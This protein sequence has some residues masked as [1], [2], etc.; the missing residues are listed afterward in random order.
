M[1]DVIEE[2]KLD[3][4]DRMTFSEK[5]CD[6]HKREQLK[7]VGWRE[8]GSTDDVKKKAWYFLHHIILAHYWRARESI[9]NRRDRIYVLRAIRGKKY[10]RHY[11]LD[12]DHY[13]CHWLW[14]N[15]K[16]VTPEVMKAIEECW[17]YTP[18]QN[19]YMDKGQTIYY[20]DKKSVK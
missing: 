10:Y 11:I 19:K 12:I 16:R 3:F 6:Y 20:V 4:H 5:Y 1:M 18:E 13:T 8:I 9:E 7:H 17:G 14:A 2:E 15:E